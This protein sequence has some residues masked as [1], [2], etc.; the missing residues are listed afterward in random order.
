MKKPPALT[1]P[2]VKVIRKNLSSKQSAETLIV[3]P[4]KDPNENP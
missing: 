2:V 4:D 3:Q 1:Q